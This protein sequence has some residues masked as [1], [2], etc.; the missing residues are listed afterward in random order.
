M[1]VSAGMVLQILHVDSD[2]SLLSSSC[3]DHK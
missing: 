3:V 1:S 2:K